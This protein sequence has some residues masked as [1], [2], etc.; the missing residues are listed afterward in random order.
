MKQ[1]LLITSALMLMLANL[2]SCAFDTLMQA[3]LALHAFNA[4][5]RAPLSDKDTRVGLFDMQQRT[6]STALKN[7]VQHKLRVARLRDVQK[8]V[9]ALQAA[10]QFLA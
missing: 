8:N 1:F 7:I 4:H 10:F 9:A 6:A 2:R 5:Q 3:P